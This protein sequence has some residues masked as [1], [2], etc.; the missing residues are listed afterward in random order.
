MERVL[1][2]EVDGIVEHGDVFV[3]ARGHCEIIVLGH[4]CLC[5]KKR[6]EKWKE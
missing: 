1:G 4:D 3:V 5:L 6:Y 2:I